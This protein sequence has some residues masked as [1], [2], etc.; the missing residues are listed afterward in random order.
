MCTPNIIEKVREHIA[1]RDLLKKTAALAAGVLT[2]GCQSL[3][4][5]HRSP[6]LTEPVMFKRVADLS[7][8][9]HPDF[10]A[11]FVPG[12]ERKSGER[13]SVPPA[14]VKV[15][16]VMKFEEVRV[17]LN[18]VPYWEHVGTHMDAPSHFSV[19]RIKNPCPDV[20][21]LSRVYWTET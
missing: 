18:K 16:R 13:M 1:R 15:E 21:A 12:K 4:K 9:L 14:I 5:P 6:T 8:T 2:T 10:P 11:W 17:N 19:F 20:P 3:P 7:H